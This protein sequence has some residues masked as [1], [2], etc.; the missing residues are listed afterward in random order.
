[1]IV[2]VG[3]KKIPSLGSSI[4]LVSV[5]LKSYLCPIDKLAPLPLKKLLS[6]LILFEF[7]RPGPK[8]GTIVFVL[9]TKVSKVFAPAKPIALPVIVRVLSELVSL[10]SALVGR[11]LLSSKENLLTRL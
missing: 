8:L 11:T 7:L 10:I 1:L 3:E 5:L 2:S 6:N 9:S 4:G